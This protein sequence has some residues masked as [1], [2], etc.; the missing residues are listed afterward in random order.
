MA[1]EKELRLS[2]LEERLADLKSRDPSH[3]YG[4]KGFVPHSMTP[5]LYQEIED[6]EEEIKRLKSGERA[7]GQ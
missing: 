6:L 3:C 4:T 5:R 7:S 1:E 2:E